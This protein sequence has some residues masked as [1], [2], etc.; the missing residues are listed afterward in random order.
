MSLSWHWC[1]KTYLAFYVIVDLISVFVN[2][3]MAS[4]SSNKL[5]LLQELGVHI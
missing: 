2:Y 1:A 3:K 5:N 4:M